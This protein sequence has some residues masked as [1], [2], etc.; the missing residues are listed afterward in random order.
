MVS[1][2]QGEQWCKK[3]RRRLPGKCLVTDRDPTVN[4]MWRAERRGCADEG[5]VWEKKKELGAVLFRR[6]R[7]RTTHI[8]SWHPELI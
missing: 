2:R 1:K 7:H 6:F 4:R 5:Q 3:W 8:P